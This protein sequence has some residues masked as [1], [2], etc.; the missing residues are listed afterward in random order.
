MKALFSVI[1]LMFSFSIFAQNGFSGGNVGPKPTDEARTMLELIRD[2]VN[3]P[4][5]NANN[6]GGFHGGNVGPK[7]DSNLFQNGT[8]SAAHGLTGGTIGFKPTTNSATNI[9]LG[10]LG[11]Q[12]TQ[13][14]IRAF[15]TEVDAFNARTANKG[16]EEVLPTRLHIESI[17]LSSDEVTEITLKDGSVVKVE[18]L[19]EFVRQKMK[20]KL[21]R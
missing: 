1:V 11:G 16:D 7:P 18:D 17:N 15:K 9:D 19:Q 3:N 14:Q 10:A 8:N 12:V 4:R 5:L 2:R 6:S 21:N 20:E 13:D